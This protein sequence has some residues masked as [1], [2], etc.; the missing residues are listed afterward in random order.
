MMEL[1][2]VGGL[3][4]CSGRLSTDPLQA[5]LRQNC[6]GILSHFVSGFFFITFIFLIPGLATDSFFLTAFCEK[7]ID[8]PTGNDLSS[9]RISFSFVPTTNS[10]ILVLD[11]C[12]PK[13]PSTLRCVLFLELTDLQGHNQVCLA[14]HRGPRTP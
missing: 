3:P 4:A 9:R 6:L 1:T 8:S 11:P 13:Q 12:Q 2:E 10:L 14:W 7:I 5:S